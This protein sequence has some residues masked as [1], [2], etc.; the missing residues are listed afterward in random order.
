MKRHFQCVHFVRDLRAEL[1]GVVKAAIDLCESMTRLGHRVVLTT[2]DATDGPKVASESLQVVEAPASKVVKP[3]LSGQALRQIEGI[4]QSADVAHLHTPWELANLQWA[5]LLRRHKVPYVVSAHGMLDHYC[6]GQKRLKK[7]AFLALG[8]RRLFRDATAIHFTAQAELEQ[9]RAYIPV[10]NKA[11]VLPCVMDLSSYAT[12][13]GPEPALRA[14]PQIRR[15]ARKILF[16]SRVHPKKGV[17]LLIRAMAVVKAKMPGAQLLIAGPGDDRYFAELKALAERL[18]ITDVVSFLG[19]ARGAEKQS[20]Y[21]VADVFVLPTHQE[22][23][24]LVLAE[25][26]ACGAPVITTR[27]TDIWRELEQGGARIVDHDPK[28][29][30]AEIERVLSDLDEARRQGERGRQFVHEW[31]DVDQVAAGYE[32]MYLDAIRRGLPSA[33]T[34]ALTQGEALAAG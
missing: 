15:E 29:I 6:M 4:I 16:L 21:Q 34:T 11:I 2:C 10:A 19:M 5:A 30:A 23:F 31:L 20:L 12:L 27:G 7:Q 22:N 13:S 9:A 32:S 26:M 25:A 33:S 24:G 18:G 1:G 28:D 8:G 3:M 17:D 14:Y